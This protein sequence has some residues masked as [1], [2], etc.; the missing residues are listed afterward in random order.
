MQKQLNNAYSR[1]N[2]D[3]PIVIDRIE[4]VLLRAFHLE[5]NKRTLERKSVRDILDGISMQIRWI[6]S[7][8]LAFADMPF[9]SLNYYERRM[10]LRVNA[11]YFVQRV[12]VRLIDKGLLI[13]A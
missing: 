3:S 2:I 5:D 12:V 6:L 10:Y 7:Y 11:E 1:L 13:K 8:D 4:F 9:E